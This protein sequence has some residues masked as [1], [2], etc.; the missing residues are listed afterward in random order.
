[1]SHLEHLDV[2]VA[3]LMQLS[4]RDRVYIAERLAESVSPEDDDAWTEELRRRIQDIET[5]A[6]QTILADEVFREAEER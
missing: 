4:P 3:D 2:K 1:M 6:V 5:D